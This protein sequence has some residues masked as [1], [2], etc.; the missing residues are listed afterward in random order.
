MKKIK[1]KIKIKVKVKIKIFKIFI[2]GQGAP[3]PVTPPM[4]KP[5]IVVYYP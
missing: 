1:I 3:P 2:W 4:L 5:I